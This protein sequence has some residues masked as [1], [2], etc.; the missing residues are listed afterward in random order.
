MT[1]KIVLQ[2]GVSGWAAKLNDYAHLS[3]Q[4]R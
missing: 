1:D 4:V 2:S 3:T